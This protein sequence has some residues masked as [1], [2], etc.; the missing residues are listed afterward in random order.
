MGMDQQKVWIGIIVIGAIVVTML[1]YWLFPI[2]VTHEGMNITLP[3]RWNVRSMFEEKMIEEMWKEASIY[4][5]GEGEAGD[6][7]ELVH[8]LGNKLDGLLDVKKGESDLADTISTSVHRLLA[9]IHVSFAISIGMDTS[10]EM[11]KGVLM[12]GEEEIKKGSSLYS[13]FVAH[14][15]GTTARLIGKHGKGKIGSLD[16]KRIDDLA[17]VFAV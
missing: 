15:G 3:S 5:P 9:L 4:M 16:D 8:K 1:Y 11:S 6:L 14:V 2:T 12:V 7:Q 13:T 10:V 17:E